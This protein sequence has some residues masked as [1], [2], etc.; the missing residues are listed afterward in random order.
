MYGWISRQGRWPSEVGQ[1]NAMPVS[2]WQL[3]GM[4]AGVCTRQT[5]ACIAVIKSSGA[6]AL[7]KLQTGD[8]FLEFV[9]RHCVLRFPE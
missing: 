9:N 2:E 6:L 3:A 8:L 7:E 4:S 5:R 1:K